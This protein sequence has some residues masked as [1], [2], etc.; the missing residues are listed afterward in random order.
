MVKRFLLVLISVAVLDR[1]S[2]VLAVEFL[3]YS[4]NTGTLFGMLKGT[5]LI[6]ILLTLAIMAVLLYYY[7]RFVKGSALGD[8]GAG[9]IMGGA[10][11]NLVDRL[12]Y[13]GVIDFIDLKFWPSF[14]LA[15]S[16]LVIGL[17]LFAFKNIKK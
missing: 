10:I 2:K 14:N 13:G 7:F 1:I 9:L 11:G 16:A 15:D 8:T 12:A 17:C 3:P 4:L 6:F 5:N